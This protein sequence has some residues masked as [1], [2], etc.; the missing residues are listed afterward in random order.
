MAR[1]PIPGQDRGTWGN[2]LNEYLE[3]SH[4]SDGSLK[5]GVVQASTISG[6][7][8]QSKVANLTTDLAAKA[9][10]ASLSAVATTGSYADLSNKP[11]LTSL[12]GDTRYYQKTET[13]PVIVLNDGDPVPG[14]TPNGTVVFYRSV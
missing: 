6:T 2:M 10:A 12:G 9:N 3:V 4:S 8:P 5:D 14:G 1:L 7:L 11:T 13:V